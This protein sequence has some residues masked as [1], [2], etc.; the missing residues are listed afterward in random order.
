M[1]IEIFELE[2][3]Q[4]LY[5]NVVEYNLTESGLHPYTLREL[6]SEEEIDELK[7][8]RLGYGQTNGSIELRDTISNLYPGSDRENILVTN[9]SAEANFISIWSQFEADDELVLMLPNYM[10]IWGLAK[11]M[12]VQ[13]KPFYLQESLNWSPN[14]EE[15]RKQITANTKMIALCN[16]NNPTGTVLSEAE[17]KEIVAMAKEVGAWIYCDEIYRGAE[18]DGSEIPSFYGM[19]DK[20]IVTGGLSKAYGLPG[21]RMGWLAGPQDFIESAWSYNDYVTISTGILSQKITCK[22][23][24]PEMRKKVL[25]RNRGMLRENIAAVQK[26]INSHNDLFHMVPPR[27]G[28]MAFLRYNMNINSRE[29]SNRLRIEKSVFVMDGNCFGMDQYIRIGFGAEKEYLLAGLNRID[30][31]LKEII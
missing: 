7:D 25:S 3:I 5:E 19:Y 12:G 14:L 31:L 26:W 4:S 17:M 29:L 13:V 10:Q 9:G 15:I 23:L 16:P 28:G 1:K 11:S 30:D 27:A 6:L 20:V 8:I 24:Q 2:R 21:L 18:L 22:V